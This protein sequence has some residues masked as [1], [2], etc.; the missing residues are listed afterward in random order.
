MSQVSFYT[1][2]GGGGR[3]R[4]HVSK[5]IY[6]TILSNA[7]FVNFVEY[8]LGTG[9]KPCET[10]KLE[11]S[12]KIVTVV[13][14]FCKKRYRRCLTGFWIR[15]WVLLSPKIDLNPAV[16]YK[17]SGMYIWSIDVASVSRGFQRLLTITKSSILDIW[18]GLNVILVFWLLSFSKV[19]DWLQC[20]FN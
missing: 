12:A 19:G 15:L 6:P 11:L 2:S 9:S 8:I 5:D 18:L 13:N 7:I 10:S 16:C 14:Y 4:D 17:S 20:F 3:E 1:L